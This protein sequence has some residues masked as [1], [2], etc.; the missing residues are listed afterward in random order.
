MDT[1]KKSTNKVGYPKKEHVI[2]FRASFDDV[3]K[4][5][6][7]AI[8]KGVSLSAYLNDLFLKHYGRG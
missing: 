5:K 4:V 8:H 2:S 1:L 6:R 3:D 7:E